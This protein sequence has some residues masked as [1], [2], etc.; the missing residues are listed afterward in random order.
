MNSSLKCSLTVSQILE[1]SSSIRNPDLANVIQKAELS[2][3]LKHVMDIFSNLF[4]VLSK[5]FLQKL[6]F[7]ATMVAKRVGTN[8]TISVFFVLC[9][10]LLP[11]NVDLS[12]DMASI[13][14]HWGT[15]HP[16]QCLIFKTQQCSGGGGY[17][18]HL[19][20]NLLR[21]ALKG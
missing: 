11:Y 16:T 7:Q 1:T 3:S 10:P 6:V 18:F 14:W 5:I 17:R 2:G 4:P 19:R 9:L 12:R 8:S 15:I 21:R 13:T 20:G